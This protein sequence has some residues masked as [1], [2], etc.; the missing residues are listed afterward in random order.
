[1]P[2]LPKPGDEVVFWHC[3]T[4]RRGRCNGEPQ[5]LGQHPTLVTHLPVYHFESD[6][7]LMV[8]VE[9]IAEKE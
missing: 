8:A 7:C 6:R 9:N 5:A 2:Q 1:M 3:G 4:L